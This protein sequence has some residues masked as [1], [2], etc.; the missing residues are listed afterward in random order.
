MAAGD[1]APRPRDLTRKKLRA[2]V[3]LALSPGEF[4][5]GI[6]G[7]DDFSPDY[8]HIRAGVK[9]PTGEGHALKIVPTGD[10]D[11]PDCWHYNP[12]HAIRPGD[13]TAINLFFLSGGNEGLRIPLQAGGLLEQAAIMV[14]AFNVIGRQVAAWQK[15][16]R[17]E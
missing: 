8:W 4:G 11:R 5:G 10:A 6:Y 12:R 14:D 17:G 3:V 13:L 15:V 1:R 7:E 2:A 16:L 9:D